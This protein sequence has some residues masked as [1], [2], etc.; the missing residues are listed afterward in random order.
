MSYILELKNITKKFPGVIANNDISF[1]VEKGSIHTLAGENGA[2]KSTL[3]NIIFGLYK[4][5]EG[6]IYVD[7]KAVNFN[8]SKDSI[9]NKIG[10]VHQ[11]FMLVPKLTVAENIIAGDEP[12]SAFNVD[13]AKAEADITELSN[14]YG[15]SI[16]PTKKVS[17]LSVNEQQRVEIIKVLYR[18]AEIL[19]FDEPTAVLTPQEIDEFCKILLKLKEDGKTII[20]ISHKLEEVFRISDNITV[21]RLGKVIGTKKISETSIE[22]VTQM[23][24]GRNVDLGRKQRPEIQGDTILQVSDV[25]YKGSGTL[26]KLEDISFSLKG[27]EILG[28]AGIDGNGQQELVEIITGVSSPTS[29]QVSFKG[30]DIKELSVRQRKDGGIACIPEDRHKQGL[31]LDYSIKD[32]MVLGQQHLSKF[33]S[34]NLFLNA[35]E[36]LINSL[37]LK[38]D[39][40]VR[41]P[42]T[43]VAVQTLSGGNQQKVIIAREANNNPELLI[44]VQPTRGLDVGAEEF[45]HKALYE[46]RNNGKAVLLISFELDEVLAMSDRIMVLHEGKIMDIVDANKVTRQQVGAMMLGIHNEEKEKVD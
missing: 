19:I 17:E 1:G 21:I 32:N 5:T 8:S 39:F 38:D 35:K 7:G 26:N 31:V 30:S 33:K 20:F 45:V 24:V 15:F 23:M 43:T 14:Q 29:G 46:M 13:R 34:K 44:A 6:Q 22:D 12:G 40:D 37:K 25:L 3:M 10:M 18:K 2:G 16:D 42:D 27:G 28:V 9:K 4:P 36:I 11:H 41:C